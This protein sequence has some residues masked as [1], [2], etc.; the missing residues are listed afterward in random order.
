M[1]CIRYFAKPYK[2]S[3]EVLKLVLSSQHSRLT[4]IFSY[5]CYNQNINRDGRLNTML[6]QLRSLFI[7]FVTLTVSFAQAQ[8]PSVEPH[9]SL[10]LQNATFP[11]ICKA[12]LAK[13]DL[14]LLAELHL[15]HEPFANLDIQNKPVS[16]ALC[17]IAE[18]FQREV[19]PVNHTTV[20]R[21]PRWAYRRLLDRQSVA[22]G[23]IP[24]PSEGKVEVKV[25]RSPAGVVRV[26]V[27]A[28]GVSVGRLVQ[29]LAK[30]TGWVVRVERELQDVRVLARWKGA[31][32][33]EVL[34]ALTVLLNSAQEVAIGRSEEA[35][36]QE[37]EQMAEVLDSRTPSEKA[38]EKLLPELLKLLTP[39]ELARYQQGETVEIS[40][41]RVPTALFSQVMDYATK[42]LDYVRTHILNEE[43]KPPAD[44]LSGAD[45]FYMILPDQVSRRIGI[46][47][48]DKQ[49]NCFW[50]F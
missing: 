24:R 48:Y 9:I 12:L 47:I 50:V 21:S 29:S 37:E 25:Q 28:N 11:Q 27:E 8:A 10:N 6:K 43:A 15:V 49:R 42:H 3:S 5:E 14:N 30:Q 7:A 34:E 19:I 4:C 38:T 1:E 35:K 2:T 45:E 23:Y 40:S 20:L 41:K 31:S 18:M 26:D 17:E 32:V 46:R 44:L 39:E 22:Q 13:T 33:S 36:R 16:S